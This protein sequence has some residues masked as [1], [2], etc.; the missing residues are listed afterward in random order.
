ME[1]TEN[2]VVDFNPAVRTMNLEKLDTIK[3][4]SSNFKL[5]IKYKQIYNVTVHIQTI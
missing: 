2:S 4:M 1:Q 3:H 5:N